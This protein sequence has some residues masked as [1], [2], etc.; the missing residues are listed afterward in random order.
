MVV[1]M[2]IEMVMQTVVSVALVMVVVVVVVVSVVT[3]DTQMRGGHLMH[4]RATLGAPPPLHAVFSTNP[5]NMSATT[6]ELMPL[7]VAMVTAMV[8]E[9]EV[10]AVMAVGGRGERARES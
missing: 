6:A 5:M 4:P 9:V 1:A 10:V 7:V 2:M 8:V 3:A